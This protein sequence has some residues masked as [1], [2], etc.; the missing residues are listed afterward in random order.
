MKQS[1]KPIQISCDGGAATGKS[2]GAR[3]PHRPTSCGRFTKE[4]IKERRELSQLIKSAQEHFKRQISD[5]DNPLL[6]SDFK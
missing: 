4:A 3:N 2:T 1:N 5:S 6:N